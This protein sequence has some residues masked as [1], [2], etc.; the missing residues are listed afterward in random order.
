M[1]PHAQDAS[2][3]KLEVKLNIHPPQLPRSEQEPQEKLLVIVLSL[4][5]PIGLLSILPDP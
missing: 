2:I 5:H 1:P 3:K 4:C